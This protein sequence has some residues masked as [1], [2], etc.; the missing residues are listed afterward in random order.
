MAWTCQ[1]TWSW[2]CHLLPPLKRG[3]MSSLQGWEPS[4]K[5]ATQSWQKNCWN[6][7]GVLWIQ[8]W[9]HWTHRTHN[10]RELAGYCSKSISPWSTCG[11]P[12]WNCLEN[13]ANV[14]LWWTLPSWPTVCKWDDVRIWNK[15]EK[16]TRK[17]TLHLITDTWW[18]NWDEY[19]WK[20][21]TRK[22]LVTY[23]KR[24]ENEKNK[25]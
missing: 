1:P 5:T 22:Q 19:Q 3:S 2:Q 12:I 10:L 17:L 24:K 14:L 13:G 8:Q 7:L 16:K 25:W 15:T 23:G 11:W 18:L 20:R 21:S 4:W 6:Q 9:S